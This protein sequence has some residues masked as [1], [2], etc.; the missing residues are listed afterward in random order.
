[1]RDLA[2]ALPLAHAIPAVP[3]WAAIATD[4]RLAILLGPAL[5]VAGCLIWDAADQSS[6]F[7][8]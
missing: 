2:V 8:P 4:G 6:R 7:R 3:A 5:I 1:M